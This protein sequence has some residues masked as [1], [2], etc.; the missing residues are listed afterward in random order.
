[1]LQLSQGV[2]KRHHYKHNKN[3]HYIYLFNLARLNYLLQVTIGV[4]R[5]G[6]QGGLAPPPPKIG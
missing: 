3:A 4:L 2:V 6:G 5:G 1:M